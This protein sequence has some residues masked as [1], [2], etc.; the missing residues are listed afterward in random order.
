MEE[1]HMSKIN[2]RDY[3]PFY[4]ADLFIMLLKPHAMRVSKEK[5]KALQW[6]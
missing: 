4:N 1:S 6:K 2:L 3:Y 5:A